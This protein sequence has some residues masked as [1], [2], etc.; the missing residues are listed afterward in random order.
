MQAVNK[1]F[2]IQLESATETLKAIA[3]QTRLQILEALTLGPQCVTDI[4]HLLPV[5]QV[6][7]SQHLTVL[8]NAELVG[9][10]QHGALRCYYLRKPDLVRDLLALLATKHDAVTKGKEEIIAEREHCLQAT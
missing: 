2:G 5:S 1:T 8:R 3:H 9:F 10:V 7:V 4:E 6:N